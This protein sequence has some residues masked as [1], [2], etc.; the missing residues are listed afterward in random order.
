M[1]RAIMGLTEGRMATLQVRDIDDRLYE[2]LR[3]RAAR[4]RRS[5]SQEVILILERYLSTPTALDPN[6]TDE[7]LALA[8]SWGDDRDAATI[9]EDLR[10]SRRNS[11]R[12]VDQSD[13]LD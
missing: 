8:G 11:R 3:E 1:K 12:F 10:S 4:Q 9:V 13:V 2:S 5:I 6:P 7:F